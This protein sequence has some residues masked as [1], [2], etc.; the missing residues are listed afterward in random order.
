MRGRAFG[1][2]PPTAPGGCVRLGPWGGRAIL[3]RF[4][5]RLGC[6]AMRGGLGRQLKR[7]FDAGG[8]GVGGGG[9]LRDFSYL[10]GADFI[11]LFEGG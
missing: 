1:Q 4:L 7:E 5:W 6:R 8:L 3:W 2:F 11:E 9:G 10:H